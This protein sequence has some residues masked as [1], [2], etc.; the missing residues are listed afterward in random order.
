MKIIDRFIMIILMEFYRI[1][2]EFLSK[3]QGVPEGAVCPYYN[4]NS[5]GILTE[6]LS[7]EVYP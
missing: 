3:I 1:H 4:D 6:L 5:Y 2:T 7:G